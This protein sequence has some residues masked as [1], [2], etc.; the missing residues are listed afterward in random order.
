MEPD[1]LARWRNKDPLSLA[2]AAALLCDAEP[3]LTYRHDKGADAAERHTGQR[4]VKMQ[5]DLIAAIKGGELAGNIRHREYTTGGGENWATREP[6]P[7]N[8]HRELDLA[9]STVPR[10][11]LIAWT[12]GKW[13]VPVAFREPQADAA[14]IGDDALETRIKALRGAWAQF[15][16]PVDRDDKTSWHDTHEIVAWFKRNGFE[17]DNR[18]KAA[19]TIIRPHWAGTGR[20]P[21]P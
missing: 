6:I 13:S 16:E 15:W 1:R 21:K 4:I 8:R 3:G 20:K 5:R 17:S 11:D 7:V 19:A 10:A 2:E 12:E 14:P 18:A 9:L